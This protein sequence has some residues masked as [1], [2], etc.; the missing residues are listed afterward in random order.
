VAQD[1]LPDGGAASCSS[2]MNRDLIERLDT[3]TVEWTSDCWWLGRGRQQQ[4]NYK[5]V[6]NDM[7]Y[8]GLAARGALWRR[9][10]SQM[11]GPPA[12]AAAKSRNT[13]LSSGRVCACVTVRTPHAPPQLLPLVAVETVK[14]KHMRSVATHNTEGPAISGALWRQ[15]VLPPFVVADYMHTAAQQL[16][17]KTQANPCCTRQ[18]QQQT[19]NPTSAAGLPVVQAALHDAVG[20]E[21]HQQPVRHHARKVDNGMTQLVLV[22][23]AGSKAQCRLALSTR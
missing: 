23:A 13:I 19:S 6:G 11:V 7:R 21:E 5:A 1:A 4:Q 22:S 18:Q 12:A 10:R 3:A 17:R 15:R 16:A 14:R 8:W 20:W 9:M 2:E